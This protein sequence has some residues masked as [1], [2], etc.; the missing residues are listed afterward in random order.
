VKSRSNRRTLYHFH[1]TYFSLYIK[2]VVGNGSWSLKQNKKKLEINCLRTG[3][4][5][6]LKS[7]LAWKARWS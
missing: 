4:L 6:G 3:K 1:A 5:G 7:W 2:A